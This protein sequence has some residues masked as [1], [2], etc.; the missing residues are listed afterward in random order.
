ME[1]N[2]S[3]TCENEKT[4]TAGLRLFRVSKLPT[5]PHPKWHPRIDDYAKKVLRGNKRGRE[6][7]L[8]LKD[9]LPPL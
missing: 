5:T 4:K 6:D 3:G 2:G 9:S 8:R 7:V 1:M